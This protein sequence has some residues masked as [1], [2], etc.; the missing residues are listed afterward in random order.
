VIGV[1]T[2]QGVRSQRFGI[3]HAL[4]HHQLHDREITVCRRIRALRR[5]PEGVEA[6]FD[7]ERQA[8]VFALELLL[9]ADAVMDAARTYLAG[10]A[11]A[12]RDDLRLHLAGMFNVPQL[13]VATR[14]VGLAILSP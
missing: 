1:N 5:D 11:D 10:R 12:D 2:G 7:M 3:A 6:D 4:G 13:A 8:T 14:L 9:P